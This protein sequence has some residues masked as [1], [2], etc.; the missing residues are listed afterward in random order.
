MKPQDEATT[1]LAASREGGDT[2]EAV[3]LADCP[4]GLFW[5]DDTLCLKTEY[6]NNEGR[7]DAYIVESGEFYWGD[8]PQTIANQRRQMVTPV[9]TAHALDVLASPMPETDGYAKAFYEIADLLGI[10]ARDRAPQ[11]VWER[12]MRPRLKEALASPAPM[13]EKLTVEDIERETL[14]LMAEASKREGVSLH[15]WISA[16]IDAAALGSV[17]DKEGEK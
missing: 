2:R 6:G 13:P 10:P 14:D 15:Q 16:R 17:Q 3:T 5:H 12:E 8:A 4:I 11:Q 1:R 9:D 7:I